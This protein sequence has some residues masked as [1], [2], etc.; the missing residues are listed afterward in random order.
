MKKT[1]LEEIKRVRSGALSYRTHH[2]LNDFDTSGELLFIL[3]YVFK[4]SMSDLTVI[5]SF[6]KF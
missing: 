4:S 2:F 5:C 1:D 3:F 6:L